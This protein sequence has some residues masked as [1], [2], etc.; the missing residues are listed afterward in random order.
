V[1]NAGDAVSDI[2]ALP[3][4]WYPSTGT[5][6]LVIAQRHCVMCHAVK[7]THESFREAPK[8]LTLE[9]VLDLKKYVPLVLLQTAQNKAMP[10]GDQTAMTD[11]ERSALG[12]WL[13]A[14][15]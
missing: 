3:K 10:F 5:Q 1:P 7:P 13:K 14:L 8:N 15:Q 12:R 9:T 6:A 4:H 11:E 2:Q